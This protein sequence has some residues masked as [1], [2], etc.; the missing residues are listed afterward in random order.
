MKLN[1]EFF[2]YYWMKKY[3][4]KPCFAAFKP[5]NL[6]KGFNFAEYLKN[7]LLETV[8]GCSCLSS[9]LIFFELIKQILGT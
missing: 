4:L 8:F 2:N 1:I 9:F 5:I 6:N 7:C 3:F